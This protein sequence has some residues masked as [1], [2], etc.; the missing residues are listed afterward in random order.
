MK[1]DPSDGAR[2]LLLSMGSSEYIFMEFLSTL[3]TSCTSFLLLPCTE[4]YFFLRYICNWVFIFLLNM[5]IF[6]VNCN[7]TIQRVWYIWHIFKDFLRRQ[8]PLMVKEHFCCQWD[9]HNFSQPKLPH[10]LLFFFH[11]VMNV[12]FLGYDGPEYKF[13]DIYFLFEVSFPIFTS[14]R[15]HFLRGL[16]H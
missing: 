16:F 9:F 5:S 13:L 2:T 4:C 3:A 8:I 11:H 1:T 14:F 12:I 6:F 10:V 15:F 7:I